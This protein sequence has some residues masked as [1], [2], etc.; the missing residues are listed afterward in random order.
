MG[1]KKIA[2]I[3]SMI[4]S[5]SILPTFSVKALDKQVNIQTNRAQDANGR[6]VL[7]GVKGKIATTILKRSATILRSSSLNSVLNR[8]KYIGFSTST[9]NNINRYSYEVADILD[10]LATWSYVVKTTIYEQISGAL[11]GSGVSGTVARDVAWWIATII[12]WGLF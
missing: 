5:L 6:N 10:E 3:L 4:F 1:I 8:L 7:E 11:I 12:D 2:I 9:I